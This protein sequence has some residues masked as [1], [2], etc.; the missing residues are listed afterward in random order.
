MEAPSLG[1]DNN[2]NSRI[3]SNRGSKKDSF[4]KPEPNPNPKQRHTNS[5]ISGNENKVNNRNVVTEG[6]EREAIGPK[7]SIGQDSKLE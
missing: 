3:E 1:N 6:N 5:I 7:E 4:I 2:Q